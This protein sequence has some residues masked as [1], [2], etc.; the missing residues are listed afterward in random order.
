MDHDPKTCTIC[1]RTDRMQFDP[2]SR[3]HF[4][5]H[6]SKAAFPLI[7]L[8]PAVRESLCVGHDPVGVV[9]GPIVSKKGPGPLTRGHRSRPLRKG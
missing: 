4:V 3:F 2:E 1:H 5:P 9:T 8:Y 6:D 7:R